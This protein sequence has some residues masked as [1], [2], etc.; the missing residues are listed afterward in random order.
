LYVLRVL[1]EQT[2]PKE[3][4]IVPELELS[5]KAI[6]DDVYNTLTQGHYNKDTISTSDMMY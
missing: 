6:F 2:K 1:I 3:A 5:Q 4:I